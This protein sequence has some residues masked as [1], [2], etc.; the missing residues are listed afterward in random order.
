MFTRVA[1][2]HA[3]LQHADGDAADHVDD[4]DDDAGD[5][6][7]LDELRG[8]VHRT[9]EVGLGR[10]LRAALA[11]LDVGD[12]A[13][14]EVGVDRHLLAGHGVEGEAGADLG[15]ALGALGDD[16]EL[17][18]DEDQEDH[19]ADD[20]RAADGDVA[21]RLDH[22]AGIALAQH[23]PGRGDVQAQPEQR[24]DEQQRRED[25]EVERLLHEHR[26]EQDHQRRAGCSR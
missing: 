24:R 14:V 2:L 12:Q 19:G 9:V 6:V 15:H 21:E 11:R 13:G 4:D 1:E 23:Q 25:R 10:D 17:D 5:R 18:D 8:A 22:L 20:D 26:R 16:D 7:T 3:A